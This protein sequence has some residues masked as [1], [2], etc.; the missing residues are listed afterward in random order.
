MPPLVVSTKC[1]N[2]GHKARHKVGRATSSDVSVGRSV[3]A[4]SP[5]L[6]MCRTIRVQTASETFRHCAFDHLYATPRSC[7]SHNAPS[8]VPT[9][10]LITSWQQNRFC[11]FF[12]CILLFRLI[13]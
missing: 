10:M 8:H 5:V 12:V 13:N 6:S 3:G 7:S 4:L 11:R 1:C 9:G 2:V